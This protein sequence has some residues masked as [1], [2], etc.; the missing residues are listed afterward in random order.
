MRINGFCRKAVI[1]GAL[2]S[3]FGATIGHSQNIFEDFVEIEDISKEFTALYLDNGNI[4]GGPDQDWTLTNNFL[5][6]GEFAIEDCGAGCAGELKFPFVIAAGAPS[7]SIFTDST[8]SVGIGTNVPGEKLH[9]VDGNLKVE[10]TGALVDAIIDFATQTSNWEI[11][12]NGTT[13]RLTF[14]S[15]GGGATTASFKFAR[16]AQENLFRVGVL[17]GDTV[18]ING[19]LVINGSQVTP[20]YVFEKDYPLES[21]EEHSELMWKNKHLPAL[22]GASANETG[23]DIVSHQFG[24]LEELEKAHIYISQLNVTLKAQGEE[25]S[26][27]DEKMRNQDER[28]VQLEMALTELLR[29]QSSEA[30]AGSIN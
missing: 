16:A 18:D 23:V 14:F 17:A 30:K 29:N 15:P 24:T 11:K 4:G 13:G 1:I 19:K 3:I 26:A 22:P 7:Y 27:Q 5:G 12:Q 21:I 10:Q 9:V 25:L 8:G 6:L 2:T 20:D 28:I